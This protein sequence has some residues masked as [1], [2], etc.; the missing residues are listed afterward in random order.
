MSLCLECLNLKVTLTEINALS[1][2]TGAWVVENSDQTTVPSYTDFSSASF[3]KDT[4]EAL[5]SS[6]VGNFKSTVLI[7]NLSSLLAVYFFLCHADSNYILNCLCC[8]FI[9]SSSSGPL[10]L[11]R[12]ISPLFILLAAFLIVPFETLNP[13]CASVQFFHLFELW[14]EFC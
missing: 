8:C 4:F 11:V 12:D 13:L 5:H 3:F 10:L 7:K 6:V 1:L 9:S 14:G 2:K